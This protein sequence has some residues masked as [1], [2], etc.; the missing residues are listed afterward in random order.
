M[1]GQQARNI[2]SLSSKSCTTTYLLMQY[3][4]VFTIQVCMNSRANMLVIT[5]NRALIMYK[6]DQVIEERFCFKLNHL[7]TCIYYITIIGFGYNLGQVISLFSLALSLFVFWC[8]F[9]AEGL[10]STLFSLIGLLMS[11]LA[12]TIGGICPSCNTSCLGLHSG[13]RFTISF[14]SCPP[15]RCA[16]TSV[17]PW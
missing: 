10:P 17:V 6:L 9:I 7:P 13:D 4:L 15:P 14:E 3:H 12:F 5:L 16:L 2:G 11:T 8:R 1:R